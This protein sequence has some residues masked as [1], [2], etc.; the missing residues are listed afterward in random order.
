MNRKLTKLAITINIINE[1][2]DKY[3]LSIRS[4]KKG[5]PVSIAGIITLF[6]GVKVSGI[7]VCMP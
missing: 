3:G 4:S 2:T 7:M 5:I 1:I 6:T